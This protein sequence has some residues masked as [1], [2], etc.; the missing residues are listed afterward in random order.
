MTLMFLFAHTTELAFFLCLQAYENYICQLRRTLESELNQSSVPIVRPQIK[1]PRVASGK[2]ASRR[3]DAEI[4]S[5]H[6]TDRSTPVATSPEGGSGGLSR[7]ETETEFKEAEAV[8]EPISVVSEAASEIASEAASE[9]PSDVASEAASEVSENSSLLSQD[10][11]S[12]VAN[13][14]AKED[15]Q[16]VQHSVSV[17]EERTMEASSEETE[18]SSEIL[19]AVR[20]ED[21][22]EDFSSV[23]AES[24]DRKDIQD[25]SESRVVSIEGEVRGEEEALSD[26][27]SEVFGDD[28]SE[29][30]C[31]LED[32]VGSESKDGP[33]TDNKDDVSAS[34]DQGK[35]ISSDE[36]LDDVTETLEDERGLDLESGV[37][38]NVIQVFVREKDKE[39]LSSNIVEDIAKPLEDTKESGVKLVDQIT[40]EIFKGLLSDC[41]R[42]AT[43]THSPSRDA[44]FDKVVS[45]SLH[46]ATVD[47]IGIYKKRIHTTRPPSKDVRRRINEILAETQSP[48]KLRAEGRIK[49]MMTTTYGVLSP[50][51]S[52]CASPNL[53]KYLYSQLKTLRNV[54]KIECNECSAQSMDKSPLY[55]L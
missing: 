4:A 53:C 19:S 31:E 20:T 13:K 46:E 52:P 45:S 36:E 51:D 44:V 33:V 1:Q 12:L 17:Q 30:A 38:S 50:D 8:S 26:E 7:D 48:S 23:D 22:I 43:F 15:L 6:G 2:V 18:I 9:V 47:I 41:L 3:Q 16:D 40:N 35:S 42:S 37:E 49:E 24:P 10:A 5:T 27:K 34:I 32:G 39:T 11:P 54:L 29:V 28:K 14:V 21:V 25:S 55:Y